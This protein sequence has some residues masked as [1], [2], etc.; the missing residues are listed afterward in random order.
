MK[1]HADKDYRPEIVGNFH[2]PLK[3]R[4]ILLNKNKKLSN[5]NY[6]YIDFLISQ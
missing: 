1:C 4:I 3:K 5:Y 6:N 2:R